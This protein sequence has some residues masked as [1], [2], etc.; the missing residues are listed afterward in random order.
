[1]GQQ[2][3]LLFKGTPP[4]AELQEPGFSNV[5]HVQV[6]AWS[7]SEFAQL[8]DRIPALASALEK[9]PQPLR[10]IAVVPF[11]TRLLCE[12]I[13]DGLVTADFSHVA[14]QAELLQ[15]YWE[16]RVEA[17]GAPA[18][19]CI[20]RIVDTMVAARALRAAFGLAAGDDPAT[21]D[22]L[23]REGVLISADQR[24]WVQFRHHLLF[25]FAA[26]R[27]LLDPDELIAGT[28]RFP[29]GDARGLMLAPALTFLLREIWERDD[30]R[31]EF[32][33]AATHLLADRQGD[34]VIRSAT[35]R[36][37]SE[38]PSRPEDLSPLAQQVIAG[39]AEA[40]DSFVHVGGALAIRLE[41][42]PDTLLGPWARLLRALVPNVGPVA[43]TVRFL[44]FRL[45]GSIKNSSERSDLGAAARALLEYALGQQTP[46]NLATAAIDLVADTYSTDPAAS[47]NLLIR[48]FEPHRLEVHASEEVP[49]ICRKIASIEEE[50]PAFALRIYQETYGFSVDEQRETMMGNSQILSLRSNAR[51]DY[52]MARYSL[53]EHIATFLERHPE[54]AVAAIIASVEAYIA[55]EHPRNAD[56]M[57]AELMVDGRT[58]RVREDWS[59]VWANDPDNTYGHDAEVLVK[60]LLDFL[61]SAELPAALLVSKQLVDQASLA[62]FWSRLFLATAERGDGLLDLLLPIAMQETFLT[63][64]DTRKDAVDVV[65]AGYDRLDKESRAAFEEAISSFDFSRFQHPEAARASFERRI[66]G[67]I[68]KQRLATDRARAVADADSGAD[69]IQNDRL[70]VVQTRYGEVE[71]YHWI[72]DLDRESPS[73]Q[74]LI[75]A[76]EVAKE[77]LQLEPPDGQ[78][79]P[80]QLEPALEAMEALAAEIDRSAQDDHLIIYAEG[81]IAL[82]LGQI[83]KAKL[84]P[85]AN[86]DEASNR[87]LGLVDIVVASRGPQLHEDTEAAFERGPSWGSPAPRVN[88]AEIVLDL[89]LQRADLYLN[90]EPVIDGLLADPHPA[91]RLQAALHLVRIWD[92]DRSGFW[93]RLGDRLKSES[94]QGVIDHVSASVLGRVLH[95]DVERTEH[96][97]LR[98]LGRFPGE[99]DRQKRMRETL[100]DL[101]AIL[102]VTYERGAAKTVLDGW[103]SAPAEHLAELSKIVATLRGAFVAGLG[104]Q[105]DEGD[106]ALRHRSHA[107]AHSI[108]LS[109]N[110]ILTA[111]FESNEHSEAEM[112][113]ARIG[114]QLLDVV[115]RELY[116]GSGAGRD[117]QSAERVPDDREM[118]QFLAEVGPTLE[119]VGDYGTPHTIYYL[120]QLLEYLLP[121]DPPKAFD[122]T[123]HALRSGGQ[124][125]GYQFES[126]GADLLVR[127]VGVFLA[128][129]KEL[130]DDHARRD[131]LIDCLEIFMDAGWPAARRL[132]YRLPEL[133]Q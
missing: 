56:M 86:N 75:A 34:P 53:S 38:Y 62:I 109:A 50:D 32:W 101:I 42:R 113:R 24:R 127:L 132:L 17:L 21:L 19:A 91:V 80:I 129:H 100:A 122:L 39:Q 103:V 49:A 69:E 33:S 83:V 30:S 47:R 41:D 77:A 67:L 82:G 9:A 90:L 48:I 131:A 76:I 61:R 52:E 72:K 73:N 118:G 98:L 106:D 85:T 111:H 108:V 117:R 97:V 23:E 11:N 114:A 26:A 68:G 25:D 78:S 44:L 28:L 71:P 10:D 115:C 36:I 13:K 1:M 31:A 63:L 45:L 20:M 105:T 81:Q 125:T 110:Q 130:F 95:P 40:A 89:M 107:L 54:E 15:L 16:H 27:V 70:F 65:A 2:F 58:I 88:A 8:L 60:K 133:I 96:L 94:N 55:R 124:R 104:G 126:L 35:G 12:L 22:E 87:L 79:A 3:R 92:V 43:S 51:Q 37:C 5:R 66:F 29:K 14:S 128:D 46:Y 119:A 121:F 112:E 116:F 18:R 4:I 123:A 59:Y 102:W 99:P 74:G 6:P 84:V 64:P 93:R 57:D 7:D 120:L